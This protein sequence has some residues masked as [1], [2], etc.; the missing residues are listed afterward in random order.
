MKDPLSRD[1]SR[2]ER[3]LA[4]GNPI[5]SSG[6][7]LDR[8]K[9]RRRENRSED[10]LGR[11]CECSLSQYASAEERRW[12]PS[13]QYFTQEDWNV[14]RPYLDENERLFGIAVGHDLLTV[15]R[16]RKVPAEVFR[17]IVAK[18]RVFLEVESVNT[19]PLSWSAL[20]RQ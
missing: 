4:Q 9:T 11:V 2:G 12:A 3:P 20:T 17:K 5:G 14:V 10:I 16:V 1:G 18:K 15:D 19:A 8:W 7:W 13:H 6:R